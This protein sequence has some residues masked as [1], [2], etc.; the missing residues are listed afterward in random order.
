ML[1]S[2]PLAKSPPLR[3]LRRGVRD[4]AADSFSFFS[5]ALLYTEQRKRGDTIR[6]KEPPGVHVRGYLYRREGEGIG[7]SP[8]PALIVSVPLQVGPTS[9][10]MRAESESGSA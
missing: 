7:R 9:P 3:L 6:R 10:A 2:V 8:R 4:S 1:V 5:L